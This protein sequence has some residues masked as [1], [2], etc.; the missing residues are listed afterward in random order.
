[1]RSRLV[2]IAGNRGGGGSSS[3]S[4]FFHPYVFLPHYPFCLDL[5][6]A[7]N[8]AK[9]ACP[10]GPRPYDIIVL[11]GLTGPSCKKNRI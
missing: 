11:P 3:P 2:K 8:K 4:I 9:V 7:R 10:T 6:F 5:I 1:M